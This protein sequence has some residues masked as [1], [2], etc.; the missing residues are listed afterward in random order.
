MENPSMKISVQIELKFIILNPPPVPERESPEEDLVRIKQ[1]SMITGLAPSSI[2]NKVSKNEIPNTK[3]GKFLYFSKK[4]L[5]AWIKSG[6]KPTLE[7]I[8]ES[9]NET[10]S[11]QKRSVGIG[12]RDLS[13]QSKQVK[14]FTETAEIDH[15]NPEEASEM[16]GD[17]YYQANMD[18]LKMDDLL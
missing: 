3:N 6:K 7:E 15:L 2:Y 13:K 1:A 14:K 5:L 18:D 4:E 8:K 12:Q 16:G 17:I 9:V 11:K 10:L